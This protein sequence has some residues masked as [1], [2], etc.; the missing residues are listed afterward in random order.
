MFVSWPQYLYTHNVHNGTWLCQDLA[1]LQGTQLGAHWIHRNT[2]RLAT[3]VQTDG[4]CIINICELQPTST[5]LLCVISSFP[6]PPYG[7]SFSFSPVSFHACF[8]AGEMVIVLDIQAS[9]PLLWIPRDQVAYQP[10]GQF[11]P[12]GCFFACGVSPWEIC[13]WQNTPTG[14][15]P[16][17]GLRPRL[18]FHEFL[19]SPDSTS[20]MCQCTGGILLL[21]PVNHPNPL[22]PNRREPDSQY[23][24]HLVAYSADHMHIAVAPQGG[25]V[26]MILNTLLGTTWGFI[27]SEMRIHDIKIIDNTIFAVDPHR[28]VGWD[29]KAGK[30]GSFG[31]SSLLCAY[32]TRR[33]I[34]DE[35]LAIGTH[36]EHLRLSHDCSQIAFTRGGWVF[37]YN[38]KAQ[39]VLKSMEWVW[40]TTPEDIQFSP[41]G[42]Q[43]WIAGQKTFDNFFYYVVELTVEDWGF[44]DLKDGWSWANHFSCRYHVKEG[45]VW[46]MD[47]KGRKILWLPPDWRV[48]GWKEVKWLGNS[49]A[50]VGA[51]NPVPI[52]IKFQPHLPHS[53]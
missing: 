31:L 48:S 16:W 26:I 8:I 9:K 17:G 27:R 23:G 29:L 14:Y 5:T 21:D 11:S 7:G 37:L 12:D 32:T 46:V 24:I 20:I 44:V 30:I 41:D 42:H 51:H 3:S 25:G 22:S 15:V 43:L 38:I 4:K 36:A 28:V 34:I 45:S 50:L 52:I 10:L 2:L 49:L 1:L 39:K 53:Y 18:S 35:T 47:S 40:D 6:I 19:W 33:A 13:V